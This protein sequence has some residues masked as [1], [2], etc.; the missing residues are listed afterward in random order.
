M[1]QSRSMSVHTLIDKFQSQ[2]HSQSQSQ[3]G[4]DEDVKRPVKPNDD[5]HPTQSTSTSTPTPTTSLNEGLLALLGPNVTSFPY[6]EQAYIESIKLRSQQEI[7]KQQYYKIELASKNLAIIQFALKSNVPPNQIAQ[8]CVSHNED[9]KEIESQIN[10]VMSKPSPTET[11]PSSNS[12]PTKPAHSPTF[13]KAMLTLTPRPSISITDPQM[14]SF[15]GHS[16]SIPSSSTPFHQENYRMKTNPNLLYPDSLNTS[17]VPP[18][19]YRFGSGSSA[20]KRP[21]SPAKIGARAVANLASPTTPYR[22]PPPNLRKTRLTTNHQRHYSMPAENELS[23]PEL[24]GPMG[25]TSSIQVKPTPAQPLT[26]TNKQPPSQQSMTSFQH[27]I[28]FHHWKPEMGPTIGSTGNTIFKSHKRHKSSSE[29]QTP[30]FTPRSITEDASSLG[31]CRI[32]EVPTNNGTE[33]RPD[34]T[35]DGESLDDTD[36]DASKIVPDENDHNK[37]IL[38]PST[39]DGND[40]KRSSKL[41]RYP[42][43][44]LS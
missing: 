26:T 33:S 13:S 16:Q 32:T 42:Q 12:L 40:A 11:A 5:S 38:E 23:N 39:G 7:T 1:V 4:G 15:H 14:R 24:H 37:S 20:V 17:L 9:L 25:A 41:G 44:I 6:G 3:A 18:M 2:S 27:I 43:D 35:I 36:V 8:M 21:L 22:N 29:A 28:Q 31:P 34:D 30:V 19:N 10:A